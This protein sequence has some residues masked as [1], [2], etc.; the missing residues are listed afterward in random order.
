M[1]KK[2]TKKPGFA[3]RF[4]SV[5]GG[6]VIKIGGATHRVGQVAKVAKGPKAEKV[7]EVTRR[8]REIKQMESLREEELAE[9]RK[10][11]EE[12]I[13]EARAELKRPLSERL[14]DVFYNPLKRPAQRLAKFFKS[15][16]EDLYRANLRIAPERYAALIIGTSLFVGAFAFILMLLFLPI[17]FALIGGVLA[18]LLALVFGKTKPGRKAKA[19]VVE[20]NRV[21]PFALRHM[22]T[23]LSSGVG[24]PETMTSISQADYGALSEE[25]ARVIRDMHTGMSTEEA[26]ATM[27]RR[28][29]SEPLRRAIRQ[30]QRTLRTG[31]DLANILKLLADETA[32]EMRMKLRDYTQSLNMLTMIYMFASAVIPAMLLVTIAVGSSM[33]GTVLTPT[34]AAVLFLVLLPFLL[35]YFVMMI[36]RFEP[37]L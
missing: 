33:G 12:K 5:V 1:P 36:K 13:W 10:R 35:F 19:R 29:D 17:L 20:V 8:L 24:L 18:S 4:F 30:I 16:D 23:H 37:R 27:D 2:K 34:S 15:L 7:D 31:G 3:K 11:R 22:A 32:F 28:V 21:I 26:L 6:G 14:S 25:F 9:K